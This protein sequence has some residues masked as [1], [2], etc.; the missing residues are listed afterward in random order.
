MKIRF[1]LKRGDRNKKGECPI[2]ADI[3]IRGTRIQKLIGFTISESKW[4]TNAELVKKGCKNEE[5]KDYRVINSRIND[6]ITQFTNFDLRLT[7]KPTVEALNKEFNKA[8][9]K[10]AATIAAINNNYSEE[11]VVQMQAEAEKK[12][13]KPK[14]NPAVEYMDI[15]I[16]EES[17]I[18]GW[19]QETLKMVKS[20]KSHLVIF[21]KNAGLDYYD[22]SGLEAFISYL[23]SDAGLEESS[24][25]KHYNNLAWFLRWAIKKNYTQV[26]D[27]EAYEPVFKTVKKPVIFLTPDE[28]STLYHF[29]IPQNGTVLKLKTHD[30]IEYEKFVKE[31]DCMERTRDLFCFCAF[32][33]LR[34]SDLVQI[35]RTDIQ[36]GVLTITTQ[37]THD[38]LPIVLHKNAL[39]ILEKYKGKTFSGGKALPY[40]TNQQ[41]NRC[42]KDICEICGFNTPYTVTCYRNGVRHDDVYPKYELI[43]THAGRKTFICFALSNNVAPDVVMKFTGHSDYKSMKPYI[44]ITEDAKK[45]AITIMEKAW[46]DKTETDGKL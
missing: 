11:K 44:D 40:I 43:S 32:T 30:G 42:L 36:D 26:R 8:V 46:A 28:L 22:S 31:S 25:Q 24:A 5:G 4:D 19:S 23:R 2:R 45:D 17:R 18:K 33:G 21:K 34:Y 39:A 9:N 27:V 41:M 6:I 14:V 15:F 13:P 38:R 7:D 35:R 10:N 3:N 20:L 29:E 16:S 37:K 12:G 1:Y